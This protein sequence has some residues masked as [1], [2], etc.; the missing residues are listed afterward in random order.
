ML[1]GWYG[2]GGA[3][4]IGQTPKLSIL[5]RMTRHCEE[6]VAN[7]RSNPPSID[8]VVHVLLAGARFENRVP[9][10]R[11]HL[12][13]RRVRR[14]RGGSGVNPVRDGTATTSSVCRNPFGC[15]GRQRSCSS[16]C[17]QTARRSK[18]AAPAEPVVS[19]SE[20]VYACP[21]CEA[22]YL[23][24]QRCEACNTWC[25]RLG[26]GAECP[27]YGEPVSILDLLRPDQLAPTMPATTKGRR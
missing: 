3:Q 6:E 19:R 26:P 7:C 4:G 15:L 1:C 2:V 10:K 27:C 11:R 14:S 22:H 9:R 23:G 17:W 13:R 12:R 21:N 25:R 8:R 18:R 24:E 20:A 5:V 16:V